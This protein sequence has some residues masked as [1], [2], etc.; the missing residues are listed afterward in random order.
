MGGQALTVGHV[1]I[2]AVELG[3]AIEGNNRVTAPMTT[4]ATTDTIHAS[5]ATVSSDPSRPQTG[6]LTARWTYEGDQLVDETTREYNFTGT[7]SGS[8]CPAS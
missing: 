1:A 4:F 8:H 3:N 7:G 2:Q 5:V 6:S